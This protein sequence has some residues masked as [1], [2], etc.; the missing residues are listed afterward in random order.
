MAGVKFWL[1]AFI[2]RN[3]PGYTKT[4]TKGPYA[5]QTAVPLPGIARLNPLN[6]T[7]AWAAGYLTDQRSFQADF[8][9]SVR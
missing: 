9:V 8:S 1:R 3:V 2:P 7:K 4:I 5:G 6:M